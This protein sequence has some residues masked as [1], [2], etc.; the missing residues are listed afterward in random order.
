MALYPPIVASSMPAFDVTQESVKI[1]YTLSMYNVAKQDQITSVQ[2]SVRR[3]SSNVNVLANPKEIITYPFGKQD[4]IDKLFNRY[5]VEINKN[6][7]KIDEENF[8]FTEDVLYKVQLRFSSSQEVENNENYYTV[9]FNHLSEWST[10]CIIKPIQAPE[11]Y[12]QEFYIE[13][14]QPNENDSNFF[15]SNLCDWVG[16]YNQKSSSQIL[17]QWR[18]RLLSDSYTKDKL[19]ILST[20]ADQKK[21]IEFVQREK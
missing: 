19:F 13:G 15:Y 4:D 10:V 8:G 20:P 16:I 7:I 21:L 5:Y 12:I 18:L 14:H 6:Q 3:Q 1:Y 9:D 2:I 11:F 17:K